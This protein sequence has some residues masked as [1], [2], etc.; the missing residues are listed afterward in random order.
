M[1]NP[2]ET[3]TVQSIAAWMGRGV[4]NGASR[5]PKALGGDKGTCPAASSQL[6]SATA[7]Y[8][9]D[10]KSCSIYKQVSAPETPK[11]CPV[12][13]LLGGTGTPSLRGLNLLFVSPRH[14]GSGRR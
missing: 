12:R 4:R 2:W 8:N 13:V 7:S 9:V 1:G 11:P 5:G 6:C 14:I 3:T 10:S